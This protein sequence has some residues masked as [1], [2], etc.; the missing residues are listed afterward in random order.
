MTSP[1]DNVDVADPPFAD[2]VL[3]FVQAHRADFI[4]VLRQIVRAESPST[5]PSSQRRVFELLANQFDHLGFH[6]EHIPGDETGGHLY[7]RPRRR[8]RHR[9]CQLLLGH[10]DTVWDR[11]TLAKMPVRVEADGKMRGPGIFD[12]KAGLVQIIFALR[13][14]KVLDLEPDVTPVVLITSDEEIGSFESEPYI[15]RLARCT[16]RVFV[17]EPALHRDGKIKTA[18]KGTGEFQIIARGKAAHSGLDPEEG[19]SAI[20]ELSHVVQKLFALNDP[21]RG[22]TIN[23]GTI[24]GGVRTNVVA[25]EARVGVDVRVPTREAAREVESKIH[26]LSA[27]TPGVTLEVQGA[28]RRMPMERTP[29]N[30]ALWHRTE[31]L[32]AALGLS[33]EEGRSGGASDGNFTSLFTATLDGLGAVGDGAHADHEFIFVDQTLERCALMALLI[34]SPPLDAEWDHPAH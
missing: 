24:D 16:E 12:M 4:R 13:A 28:I 21:E 23:V 10:C 19:A 14:L 1:V 30:Q 15:E 34:M 7:A 33:L 26:N 17:L 8:T 2:A 22:V 18:R 3:D 11:G 20:L 5:E 6:I 31:H 29:A 25:A 27:Q 9:P 32:G